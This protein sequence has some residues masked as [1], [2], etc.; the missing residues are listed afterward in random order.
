MREAET[1]LKGLSGGVSVIV[2]T[3]THS[4]SHSVTQ[5]GKCLDG[6]LSKNKSKMS[7]V[8]RVKCV[9]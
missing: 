5:V 9:V 6:K 1:E 3:L 2:F 7:H 8:S 4:L